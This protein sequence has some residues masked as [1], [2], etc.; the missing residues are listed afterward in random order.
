MRFFQLALF[1]LFIASCSSLPQSYDKGQEHA[2]KNNYKDAIVSLEGANS[3]LPNNYEIEKS[4]SVVKEQ[5]VS[6]LMESEK[7]TNRFDINRRIKLFNTINKELSDSLMLGKNVLS[8]M[9]KE[10]PSMY[11]TMRKGMSS[12]YKTESELYYEKMEENKA[13][14]KNIKLN[15][16]KLN[17]KRL[18]ILSESE[19]IEKKSYK[20]PLEALKEF[21]KYSKYGKYWSDID[22]KEKNIRNNAVTYHYNKGVKS[23]KRKKYDDA[24]KSFQS[25]LDISPDNLM[26]QSGNQSIISEQEYNKKKYRKSFAYA[27]ESLNMYKT[28]FNEKRKNMIKKVLYKSEINKIKKM[29][30]SKNLGININAFKVY[31]YLKDKYAEGNENVI[32][33]MTKKEFE[34]RQIIAKRLARKAA[35]YRKINKY[36]YS[37]LILYYYQLS[38]LFDPSIALKYEKK[39]AF[40]KSVNKEKNKYNVLIYDRRTKNAD[41]IDLLMSITEQLSKKLK[42]ESIV[43]FNILTKDDI[44]RINLKQG[45][46]LKSKPLRVN[47]AEVVIYNIVDKIDLKEKGRDIPRFKSSKYISGKRWVHNPAYDRAYKNWQNSERTYRMLRAQR[48]RALG[49]CN[50]SGNTYLRAICRGAVRSVSAYGKNSARSKLNST[51]KQI[52]KNIIS[53]YRYTY[54]QVNVAG[55]LKTRSIIFDKRNKKKLNA[56]EFNLSVNKSGHINENVEMSDQ[57]KI[58]NGYFN[59]PDLGMEKEELKKQVVK[60]MVARLSVI[61]KKHYY[62]RFCIAGEKAFKA[63]K[64]SKSVEYYSLCKNLSE[65]IDPNID[66]SLAESKINDFVKISPEDA[67]KYGKSADI[68]KNVTQKVSESSQQTS[69]NAEKAPSRSPASVDVESDVSVMTKTIQVWPKVQYKLKNKEIKE[70]G[71]NMYK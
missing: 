9:K 28:N 56:E 25:G 59:V 50:E 38:N 26:S 35:K 58:K 4:L 33:A 21:E 42:D 5:Y 24:V 12:S 44:K 36:K 46:V 65:K 68:S 48:Q 13:I 54:Y 45:N 27:I 2:E 57:N 61:V 51:P 7:K 29:I 16:K 22:L 40:A 19:K 39:A 67:I 60:D 1:L 3:E 30:K 52:A 41:S 23:I 11:E 14:L 47:M 66:M 18:G 49:A 32:V 10:G 70:V 6:V 71:K 55:S 53:R 63:K 8:E 15:L 37:S 69:D 34:L 43:G 20:K 62:N 31:D 17:N 64:Y